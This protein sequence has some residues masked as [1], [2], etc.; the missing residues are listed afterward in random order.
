MSGRASQS[1][2]EIDAALS[3]VRNA[4]QQVWRNFLPNIDLPHLT[5]E[6]CWLLVQFQEGSAAESELLAGL[7]LFIDRPAA[8]V[9]S[10]VE[11]G[12][13]E[14]VEPDEQGMTAQERRYVLSARTQSALGKLPIIAQD[15]NQGW[16]DE[17]IHSDKE[18]QQLDF[19]LGMLQGTPPPQ[20][21]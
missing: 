3:P 5:V 16:R 19:V 10:A 14:R 1:A 12:L 11:R 13:L 17:L 15:S 20:V 2:A 8:L 18:R 21:D 6:D 7:S 9:A 4:L